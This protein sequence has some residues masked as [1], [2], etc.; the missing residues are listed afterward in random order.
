MT[1]VRNPVHLYTGIFLSRKKIQQQPPHICSAFTVHVSRVSLMFTVGRKLVFKGDLRS[2]F[3][4][5]TSALLSGVWYNY[6][7]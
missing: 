4:F 2:V 6:L 3:G 1:R 5:R 7:N